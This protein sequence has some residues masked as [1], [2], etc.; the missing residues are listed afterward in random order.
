[1]SA[2]GAFDALVSWDS[3]P[4][5]LAL[6]ALSY[7]PDG[8]GLPA[9]YDGLWRNGAVD[10]SSGANLSS[11]LLDAEPLGDADRRDVAFFV[12]RRRRDRLP[13]AP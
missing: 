2:M 6:Y 1:M 13:R 5:S 12:R 10:V 7:A 8:A 3:G 9:S 11:V 4:T